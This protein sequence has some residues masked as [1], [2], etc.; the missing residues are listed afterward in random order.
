M[1]SPPCGR[2]ARGLPIAVKDAAARLA[3]LGPVGRFLDC[4]GLCSEEGLGGV[5]EAGAT[6]SLSGRTVG[7]IHLGMIRSQARRAYLHHSNSFY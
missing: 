2:V 4:A 5:C 3:A 6:G 7:L 1:S